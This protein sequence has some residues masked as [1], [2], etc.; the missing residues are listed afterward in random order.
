MWLSLSLSEIRGLTAASVKGDRLIVSGAVVDVD[1]VP[2][3]KAS[4]KAYE[5]TRS[6]HIPPRIMDLIK[7]TDAW[8]AGKGY[9]VPMTGQAIYKRWIR[10]QD[11]T[12]KMS[13]HALRHENA[14]V[15]MAL[16]IPDTYAMQRGGWMSRQT[17][18]NIYQHTIGARKDNYDQT[19]D[20]YFESLYNDKQEKS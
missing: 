17:L 14:S 16:G 18:T 3:W 2:T 13:F 8:K 15:L 6:L 10:L 9:L 1:G 7:E 4:N 11:G 19:I 5:R 20:S 12:E